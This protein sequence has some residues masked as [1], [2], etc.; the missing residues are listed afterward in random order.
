LG[1]TWLRPADEAVMVYVPAGSFGMGSDGGDSDADSNEFPMHQVTLDAYWIDRAEVT[2]TQFELFV[3][4]TGYETTA[5]DE[6]WSWVFLE[7]DWGRKDGVDWQHPAGPGSDLNGLLQHPVL[8]VSWYDANAY[9]LWAGGRLPTEAEWEYAAR[10]PGENRY[11]WGDSFDGRLVNF[12]DAN[13]RFNFA[14]STYN[15]GYRQTAPVGS[16]PAGVSWARLLDMAGNVWEWTADWYDS[17]YYE[18]SPFTNPA[19]PSA[20]S[21]KVMRGGSW[22]FPKQDVRSAARAK[23]DP[24]L[25]F[26]SVGFRCVVPQA[27]D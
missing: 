27:V 26:D 20:G 9:C 4:D 10:G 23:R 2:N 5:E 8:H 14:N 12:C 25:R 17:D 6:G 7:T 11:P 18:V 16:Y 22:D 3:R 13:C 1:D 19:G 15:D 24:N 21:E